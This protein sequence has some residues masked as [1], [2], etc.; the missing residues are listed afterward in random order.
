MKTCIYIDILAIRTHFIRYKKYTWSF[1]WHIVIFQ[2]HLVPPESTPKSVRYENTKPTGNHGRHLPRL[3]S[4]PWSASS[5]RN[6]TCP[7]PREPSSRHPLISQRLKSKFGFK[8]G[9]PKQSVSMKPSWKNWKWRASPCFLPPLEWLFPRLQPCTDN[10]P[11]P[12][13]SPIHSSP[14][15]VTH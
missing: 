14:P 15:S 7:S 13:A 4:W 2:V 8:T 11:D 6:S 9:E 3:N 1:I 12:K 5:G 10:T